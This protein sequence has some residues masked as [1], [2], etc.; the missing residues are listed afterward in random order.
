MAQK[1]D[2][3]K[4]PESSPIRYHVEHLKRNSMSPCI[5]FYVLLDGIFLC[6]N[7]NFVFVSLCVY[8]QMFDVVL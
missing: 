8:L 1:C 3:L 4:L 7:V 2:V 6:L 5:I